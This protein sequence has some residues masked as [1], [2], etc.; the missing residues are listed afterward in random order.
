M[1]VIEENASQV[2]EVAPSVIIR[3]LQHQSDPAEKAEIF[4]W[5]NAS[6]KNRDEYYRITKLWAVRN[7]RKHSSESE[8]KNAVSLFNDKITTQHNRKRLQRIVR[9]TASTA[10]VLAIALVYVSFSLVMPK[11]KWHTYTNNA[12]E[13]IMQLYLN[14]GTRVF[15]NHEAELS[16]RGDFNTNKRNVRL[17]G[18]AYFDVTSDPAHPFSVNVG[19]MSVRVLGTSFNV[20]TGER[21][22]TILEKGRVELRD[23]EGNQLVELKPGQI[24]V[25]DPISAE[26]TLEYTNTARLTA[27]RFDQKVYESITMA[28][29]INMIEEQFGVSV[30]MEAGVLDDHAYRLVV[31]N[32]ESLDEVLETLKFIIPIEYEIDGNHVRINI[33]KSR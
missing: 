22:E 21:I 30:S 11:Y 31:G 24:A 10:A 14:D 18:E 25:Y 8:V 5:I 28:G 17:K 15:L 19:K 7:L 33:N 2:K 20:K 1:S 9:W 29:I 23:A 32:N 12:S 26:T 3:H 6:E 16:Y 13:E 27:W 4:E